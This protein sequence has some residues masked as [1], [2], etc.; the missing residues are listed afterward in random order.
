[1]K[2]LSLRGWS[3][4]PRTTSLLLA[5]LG[6]GCMGAAHAHSVPGAVILVIAAPIYG[7]IGLGIGGFAGAF[8]AFFNLGMSKKVLMAGA[9]GLLLFV[10]LMTGATPAV[11]VEFLSE[12]AIWAIM[13]VYLIALSFAY[14]LSF[15]FWFRIIQRRKRRVRGD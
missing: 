8:S 1:M 6:M 7:A 2:S 5:L 10:W 9:T 3:Q 13:V 12:P 11:L 14:N 15:M 4:A